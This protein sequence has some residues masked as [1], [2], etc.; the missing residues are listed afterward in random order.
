[1]SKIIDNNK[2]YIYGKNPVKE[3]LKIIDKG[4]LFIQN[5]INLSNINEIL[6]KAKSKNITI[7]YLE[8]DFFSTNFKDKNHQ[9]IVLEIENN[10]TEDFNEDD[11]TNAITENKNEKEVVLILDGIKDVGNLGS[12]LRSALLF[13]VNFVILPK[14][15]S[16]PVNDVVVKRSSGATSFIKVVYVT[17]IVRIISFLK[18]NGFWVYAA[19]KNGTDLKNVDFSEKSAIIMGEEGRGIRRLVKENSDHIITIPTNEKIDSLNVANAASVIL[20]SY[21]VQK[22]K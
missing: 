16:C 4:I 9:G 15:N 17:N 20:Y 8:K 21:F 5:T 19:D 13:G 22:I 14:D 2:N 12:I 11:F 10:P 7:N 3:K 1:M 18:E 6:E